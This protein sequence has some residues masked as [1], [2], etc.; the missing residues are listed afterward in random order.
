M[1]ASRPAADAFADAAAGLDSALVMWARSSTVV[2][3]AIEALGYKL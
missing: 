2:A 1:M 3:S